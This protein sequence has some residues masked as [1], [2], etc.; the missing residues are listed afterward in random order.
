M[1]QFHALDWLD[2]FTHF[3]VTLEIYYRHGFVI[4]FATLFK[5]YSVTK[6]VT[7]VIS[8]RLKFACLFEQHCIYTFRIKIK[9]TYQ[10]TDTRSGFVHAAREP[11]VNNPA[12][13]SISVYPS[14]DAVVWRKNQIKNSSCRQSAFDTCSKVKPY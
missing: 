14:P 2:I 13:S 5:K 8:L 12:A 4:S 3:L 7:I 9:D 1:K 6:S 11:R 10:A